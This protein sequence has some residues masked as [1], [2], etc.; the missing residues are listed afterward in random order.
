MTDV[1]ELN[2]SCRVA[3]WAGRFGRQKKVGDG[4]GVM[5]HWVNANI[6]LSENQTSAPNTDKR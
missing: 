2:P 3:P 1:K 4:A 6:A 5:A